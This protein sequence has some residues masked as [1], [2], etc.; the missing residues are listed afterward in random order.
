MLAQ[1]MGQHSPAF[2]N[3][4]FMLQQDMQLPTSTLTGLLAVALACT[5]QA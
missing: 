1:S 5:T 3:F 4:V 2:P